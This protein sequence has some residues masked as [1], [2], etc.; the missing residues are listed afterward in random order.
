VDYV[1]KHVLTGPA[2]IAG[3]KGTASFGL[4]WQ[5]HLG[6]VYEHNPIGD[7]RKYLFGPTAG[8]G[9]GYKF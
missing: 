4:L 2:F 9:I 5:I 7:D 3:Y 1:N 6:I 8:I